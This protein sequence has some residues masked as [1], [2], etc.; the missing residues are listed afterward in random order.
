[1]RETCGRRGPNERETRPWGRLSL[2]LCGLGVLG[3]SGEVVLAE[4]HDESSGVGEGSCSF[5]ESTTQSDLEIKV[6]T[7]WREHPDTKGME[8]LEARGGALAD[9]VTITKYENRQHLLTGLAERPVDVFQVNGGS[10]VLQFVVD[11]TLPRVC[12]LDELDDVLDIRKNYFRATWE[13]MSCNGSLY[14]LPLNVHRLN[15]VMVNLDVYERLAEAAREAGTELPPFAELKDGQQL[16]QVLELA[17]SLGLSSDDGKRIVPLSL[18]IGT[19]PGQAWPLT[20]V[21]FENLLASYGNGAYEAIWLAEGDESPDDMEAMIRRVALDLRRLRDV[22]SLGADYD[23]G[24][25]TAPSEMDEA[26]PW[27]GAGELVR[28]GDALLTIGGD[29]LRGLIED[30]DE[31]DYIQTFPYPGQE[32]TFVYTPDTFAAQ[33]LP[34]SDGAPARTWLVDVLSKVETQVGFAQAKQAIP[35]SSQLTDDQIEDLG[36]E[37]LSANYRQFK[38]C[39]EDDSSCRLLLAVSGLSPA[40]GT[41]QCFDQLGMILAAIMG[42]EYPDEAWTNFE[43]GCGRR[44]PSSSEDAVDALVDLLL[45]VSKAPY[46]SQCRQ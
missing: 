9:I 36:S 32:D 39:H 38:E 5:L 15:T 17:R 37:Y 1:M 43:D 2:L 41:N 30:E 18:C 34:D 13:P 21:A 27:Q 35:A 19:D 31:W 44:K 10:D 8:Y 20:V 11:P 6:G 40:A 42:V 4:R 28:T 12:P 25:L 3:C 23:A 45:E 33:Y 22:S 7:F 14:S 29:W 46:A 26:K 16:L 24:C